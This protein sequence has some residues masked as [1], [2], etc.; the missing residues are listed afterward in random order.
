MT[1]VHLQKLYDL[2]Q[3]HELRIQL[4]GSDLM[5]I[6]CRE[7]GAHDVCP[8]VMTEEFDAREATEIVDDKPSHEVLSL[9]TNP[10]D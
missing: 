7:C 8:S 6:V 2:C 5:R 9:P 4:S 10:A 1:C 3:R